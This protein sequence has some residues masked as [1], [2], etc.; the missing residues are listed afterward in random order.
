MQSH[1]SYDLLYCSVSEAF[2]EFRV[3]IVEISS[4]I[5]RDNIDIRDTDIVLAV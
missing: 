3:E 1:M 2:V 4:K 5:Q